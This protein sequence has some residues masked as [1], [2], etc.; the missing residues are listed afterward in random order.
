MHPIVKLT[1]ATLLAA[2]VL[3]GVAAARRALPAGLN[4]SGRVHTGQVRLLVD[5]TYRADGQSI[6]DQQIF[7]A[8]EQLIDRAERFL[9]LDMFLFNADYSQPAGTYP[10]LAQRLTDALLA[11]RADAP[12]VAIVLITDPMNTFYGST[13]QPH[14]EALRTA[15]VQV[16]E[17]NLEPLRDSHPLYSSFYR[18][19]LRHL[20]ELPGVLPNPLAPS[21]PKV[22]LGSYLRLLNFKANHRKVAISECEAVV[23]SANPHDASAPNNNLG[24]WVSGPVLAD[25]VASEAA[26]YRLSGGDP[27]VFERF[28]SWLALDS[29]TGEDAAAS[30]SAQ[31]QLVTETGIRDAAL[32]M[33]AGAGCSDRVLL[34]MFYL[35]ERSIISALKGAAARGAQ[36]QVILDQNIDAF[37]RRKTG[38]PGK[39]VAAELVK[40]GVE[41]R[42][43][44]THG[45]QFHPKYLAVFTPGQCQILAGS[46]NFT[47][48]NVSGFNLETSLRVRVPESSPLAE[49]FAAM[50]QVIWTN[51]AGAPA[52]FTVDYAVHPASTG[53]RGVLQNF[54]YRAQEASGVSTF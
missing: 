27:A 26:V 35:S 12:N 50:W 14:F 1:T 33:L 30:G 32:K 9:V 2:P 28:A 36:V 40:A 51:D 25:L 42:W 49:E 46:G 47:R 15:G 37:G 43:Y 5:L 11:K 16:M 3:V 18:T 54:A 22:S 7:D 13:P 53:L 4:V 17:T 34:G 48:R 21:A 24:F 20:P 6:S 41:V 29:E 23:S 8:V 38:L 45:E 10:A 52:L 31:V 19:Y 39:P 44:E